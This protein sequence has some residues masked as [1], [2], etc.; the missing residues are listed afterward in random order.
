MSTDYYVAN[1]DEV[2][3]KGIEIEGFIK[4]SELVTFSVAYGICDSKY[5]KF[6][7]SKLEGKQVS[8]VPDHTLAFSMNYRFKSGIYGQIGTKT[9]GETFYWN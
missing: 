7:G 1:A 3:A 6:T 5:K 9:I 2:I 4:P 8:F